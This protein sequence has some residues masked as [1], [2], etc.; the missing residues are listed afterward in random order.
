MKL[1]PYSEI[2]KL[3]PIDFYPIT[4]LVVGKYDAINSLFGIFPN[5]QF[6]SLE[7]LEDLIKSC[8]VD[9]KRNKDAE[10]HIETG[11][12]IVEMWV[13]S[14]NNDEKVDEIRVKISYNLTEL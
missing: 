5:K 7:T 1:F 11:R 6:P 3:E 14:Q 10:P 13:D 9:L 8:L 4:D 12:W 2:K